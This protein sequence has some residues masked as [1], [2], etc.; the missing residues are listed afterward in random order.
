MGRLPK[1]DG[2]VLIKEEKLLLVDGNSLLK[3]SYHGAKNEYNM[4][5]EHIG[6]IYAFMTIIRKI[7]LSDVYDRVFV[8]WDGEFS[9]KLRNDI[10]PI[11]K[12]NRQ[13]NYEKGTK[14]Q[15]ESLLIQRLK[16]KSY[17]EELCIR[18]YEDSEVEADD[19]IAFICCNLK[20]NQKATI[21]SNDS[22]LLI[23]LND[24]VDVYLTRFKEK[25]NKKNF[26]NYFNYFYSNL[27]LIKILCGDKGDNIKGI[28]LL[29]EEKLF[30]I[31]PEIKEKEVTLNQVLEKVNKLKNDRVANGLKTLQLYEN[32]INQISLGPNNGEVFRINNLLI[33]LNNPLL[34]NLVEDNLNSILNDKLNML[35]RTIDNL[36]VMMKQDGLIARI[37]T[38]NINEYLLPFKKIINKE[39]KFNIKN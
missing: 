9:G 27:L 24:Q 32:I 16:I 13:K 1:R 17:L 14:P 5:G 3:T 37:G 15:D 33:N 20:S 25:I 19:C 30:E 26:S 22:D 35:D 18:Q 39:E 34:T 2:S 12:A 7:I 4:V 29:T 6:G 23:L 36:F 28:K 38:Q 8:F 11:Y 31:M 10:Y 21:L